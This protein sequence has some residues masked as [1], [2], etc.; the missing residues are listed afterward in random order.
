ME[1]N[2]TKS[3]YPNQLQTFM[4]QLL[5]DLRAL[6]FMLNNGMIESDI[7]RIGAEQEVFLVD[8][9]WNPA[10]VGDKI[11]KHINDKHFT[12]ELG[13]F[14]LEMNLDPYVFETD[15]LSKMEK[16][17]VDLLNELQNSAKANNAYVLLTGILPTLD[18]THINT[19]NM[20]PNPR[21]VTLDDAMR[22]LRGGQ[23]IN[24]RIRG[25]DELNI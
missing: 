22:Q 12:P 10:M 9:N 1:K 25:I 23:P 6:E 13:L 5:E 19:N 11:L 3:K 20:T 16:Q 2:I 18:N 7:R 14:N 21:Y 4:K 15:C 8:K 24:F 17:L